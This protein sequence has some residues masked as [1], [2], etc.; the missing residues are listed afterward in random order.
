MTVEDNEDTTT[1]I[2]EYWPCYR[3]LAFCTHSFMNMD[4]SFGPFKI[5]QNN[6]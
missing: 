1:V 3:I 2:L 6:M 5:A 4:L